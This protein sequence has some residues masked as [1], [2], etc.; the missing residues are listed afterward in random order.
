MEMQS[1]WV[2]DKLLNKRV[3]IVHAFFRR[4]VGEGQAASACLLLQRA[5]VEVMATAADLAELV[6]D[7]I[8]ALRLGHTSIGANGI[9]AGLRVQ[10]SRARGT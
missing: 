1:C 3:G 5:D 7:A 6:V 9:W 10:A 4:Q 2:S 8:L